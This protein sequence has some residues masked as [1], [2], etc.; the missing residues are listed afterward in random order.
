MKVKNLQALQ[1]R[2]Y[3]LIAG[4]LALNCYGEH[5][6]PFDQV[7]LIIRGNQCMGAQQRI[8]IYADAYFYRL[9]ECLKEEFPATLAVVGPNE[10][11][12]LVR[13]YLVWRPPTEPSIFYAGCYLAE[14]LRN[15][16]LA[17]RWPFI[18]E[19]ARLERATLESFHAADILTLSDEIMRRIPAEQWPA[20]EL[21]AHPSVEILC[22]EWRVSDVLSAVESSEKWGAPPHQPTTLMVWR[23]G[24]HVHYRN[25]EDAE[26]SALAILREGGSFAAICEA[27]VAAGSESDQVAL[28][29]KL[30]A[31]WLA[32]GIVV[33]PD[34]LP[35]PCAIHSPAWLSVN[36]E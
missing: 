34:R 6:Q 27:L 28:I 29:G 31:R 3:Q 11:A 14:F 35:I 23:Q 17:E 7:A 19:L 18:A 21:R 2:L 25:L 32:D 15:H 36:G 8:N 26:R 5:G 12:D 9:L 24:M 30:L 22:G 13:G 33:H 16:S 4:P 20:I 10:F 1:T